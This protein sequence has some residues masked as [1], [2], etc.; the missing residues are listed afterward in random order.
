VVVPVVLDPVHLQYALAA[1]HSE[2]VAMASQV[3]L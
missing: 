3:D 1:A 2:L